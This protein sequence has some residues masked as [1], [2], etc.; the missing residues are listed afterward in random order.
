MFRKNYLFLLI[1]ISLF[2]IP[3]KGL[4]TQQ[5]VVNKYMIVK[6]V[7][8]YIIQVNGLYNLSALEL[9]G[10]Y[11]SDFHSSL[12][13]EGKYFG[14]RNGIGAS[15]VSKIRLTESSKFWLSQSISYNRQQS[16]MLIGNKANSDAGYANFNSYTGAVGI[17]Y[18][19]TPRYSVKT[20][21]GAEINASVINGNMEI[22]MQVPGNPY[23]TESYKLLNSFR[24]G[25]GVFSGA[26]F[27]LSNKLGMNFTAKYN[28]LNLLLRSADG[29]DS[30]KEFTLRDADSDNGLLF[31]GNKNFSFFSVGAGLTFY[32]GVEEKKYKLN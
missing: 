17:E 16:Y 7:P 2:F 8:K 23:N 1:L 24:L 28:C 9:G 31:S 25:F 10:S 12:V 30:D 6:S 26:T 3:G 20:F 19:F 29:V 15:I 13:K 22:W 4:F 11:N 18:N 5:T 14:T 21:A 32:F 27:M